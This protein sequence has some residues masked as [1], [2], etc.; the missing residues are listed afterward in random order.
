MNASRNLHLLKYLLPT[1]ASVLGLVMCSPAAL[2]AQAA[3][4]PQTTQGVAAPHPNQQ[5][6]MA[7]QVA[8]PPT[9]KREMKHLT[10]ALNLTPDQ[11]QKMLPI[12]RHRRQQMEEIRSNTSL[13]PQQRHQQVRSL[14]MD[15]HQKLEAV[16]TDAQKQQFEQMRQRNRERGRDRRMQ[17]DGNAPPPP[18]ADGQ[19]PPPPPAGQNAPPQA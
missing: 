16:M 10:S 2:Q 12:L 1:G 19:N 7:G 4:P 14:M 18:P 17:R 11:Q 8:H 13:T 3:P 6:E 5:P 9:P 15:T